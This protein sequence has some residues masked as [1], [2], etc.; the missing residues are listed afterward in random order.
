MNTLL[1]PVRAGFTLLEV[2]VST[3]IMVIIVL[4]VVTIASDTLRVYDR[5]V[6]DLDAQDDL[7]V[8]DKNSRRIVSLT[9]DGKEPLVRKRNEAV[10]SSVGTELYTNGAWALGF[11]II[12]WR[13]NAAFWKDVK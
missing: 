8:I 2:M 3:A 6:A 10:S 12:A 5:A 1:R 13:L 4:T 9:A 11:T 7:F